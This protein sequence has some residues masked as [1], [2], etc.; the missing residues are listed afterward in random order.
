[1]CLYL[2]ICTYTVVYIYK[3]IC[4]YIYI[5][6]HI[7]IYVN[8]FFLKCIYTHLYIYRRHIEIAAKYGR[9]VTIHCVGMYMYMS[10]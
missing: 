4:T 6:L 1:M 5:N 2:E 3:L 7:H 10:M 8:I 9:P